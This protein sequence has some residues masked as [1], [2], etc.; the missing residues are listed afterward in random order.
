MQERSGWPVARSPRGLRS[1]PLRRR[2]GP[3]SANENG[4]A[5]DPWMAGPAGWASI[6]RSVIESD[7]VHQVGRCL[8]VV[9]DLGQR[10]RIGIELAVPRDDGIDGDAGAHRI[11]VVQVRIHMLRLLT[12][13]PL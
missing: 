6:I 12:D 5:I 3:A 2:Q 7:L 9:G 4:P 1:R 8:L 10:N 11:F 13:Q